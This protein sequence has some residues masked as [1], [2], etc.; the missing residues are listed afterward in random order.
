M[1]SIEKNFWSICN[2]LQ[3]SMTHSSK[4]RMNHFKKVNYSY[5]HLKK[6]KKKIQ[7]FFGFFF[8]FFSGFFF[9]LD[10]FFH[11][12]Y[13]KKSGFLIRFFF[14]DK[15]VKMEENIPKKSRKKSKKNPDFFSDF[16]R[17]P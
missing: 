2:I 16:F 15:K 1:R 9:F 13:M 7:N 14:L 8:G 10:I 4:D 12:Y 3:E 6:S 17:W 5:V 11:F